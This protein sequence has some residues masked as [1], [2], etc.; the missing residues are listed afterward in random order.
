M[1]EEVVDLF[2]QVRD[3][4]KGR[5]LTYRWWS[6]RKEALAEKEGELDQVAMYRALSN[7]E[8]FNY[9]TKH[10]DTVGLRGSATYD[11]LYLHPLVICV[12][13]WCYRGSPSLVGIGISSKTD[14]DIF[15]GDGKKRIIRHFQ[16]G[17]GLDYTG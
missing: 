5:A 12:K 4:L 7:Y 3:L 14:H 16:R 15:G 11:L 10:L 1:T 2:R 17:Q 9:C 13:T 6:E 8:D